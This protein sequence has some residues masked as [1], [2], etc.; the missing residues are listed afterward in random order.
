MTSAQVIEKVK[1]AVECGLVDP[2]DSMFDDKHDALW[3]GLIGDEWKDKVLLAIY[4]MAA[5]Q[6]QMLDTFGPINPN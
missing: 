6:V 4:D 2:N 5:K 3:T 1:F